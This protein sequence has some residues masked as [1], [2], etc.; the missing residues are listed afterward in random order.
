MTGQAAGAPLLAP[1]RA[2]GL[3]RPRVGRVHI[4]LRDRVTLGFG[5]LA[6]ALSGLL[7]VVVGLLVSQYLQD[8]RRSSAIEQTALSAASLERALA[9]DPSD[10]SGMLDDAPGNDRASSLLDYHGSWYTTS[11]S[12]GPAALP[13]ELVSLVRSGTSAT[14]RISIG[15]RPFLAV[16]TPLGA[17]G[18]SYYELFGLD[19]LDSTYHVL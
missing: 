12:A 15:G 11:L 10:I 7:A 14:Q 1:S 2:A 17:S 13:T 5:L 4:G 18:D 9:T 8:Q 3:P 6:L 16:G 19:E